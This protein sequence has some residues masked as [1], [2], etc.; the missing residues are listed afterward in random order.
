MTAIE[1]KNK[2]ESETALSN[3]PI[4]SGSINDRNIA[5][6]AAND[7]HNIASEKTIHS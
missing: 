5:N 2:I 4:W 3:N 1:T 7:S 6:N